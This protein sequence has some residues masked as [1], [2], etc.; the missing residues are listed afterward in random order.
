[1][2]INEASDADR[3]CLSAVVFLMLCI[4]LG[5]HAACWFVGLAAFVAGWVALARRSPTFG[6]FTSA[7]LTGFLGGLFGARSG[8]YPRARR[9]RR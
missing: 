9:R 4:W 8:Y 1:M 5:P 7:F 2:T 3:I 6:W